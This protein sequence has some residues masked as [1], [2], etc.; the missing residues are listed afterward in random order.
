MTALLIPLY[1][2]EMLLAAA[3]C[4]LFLLGA[5]KSPAARRFAPILSTGV[6]LA[7]VGGLLWFGAD[8]AK[9]VASNQKTTEY[10]APF[11]FYIKLLSAAVGILFVLLAWPTNEHLTGNIALDVGA[12]VGEFFALL[13]LCIAGIFLAAGADDIIMLFL[14]IELASIPTYIMVSISRPLPV[15]QEAGVK[16]FFLGAMAAALMLFGFSYLYGT[17][18]STSLTVIREQFHPGLG[19][20]VNLKFAADGKTVTEIA[21]HSHGEEGQLLLGVDTAKNTVTI[22]GDHAANPTYVLQGA[23][24]SVPAAAITLDGAPAALGALP[25]GSAWQLLA[26]VVLLMGFAFKIAAVP[27]HSYAGDVYT[28]A[29][30]PVTALLA[31]VPK[32]TGM[33]AVIKILAVAAGSNWVSPPIIVKLLFVMAVLTMTFG[34][35]LG[36][37]Q[38]NIKRLLAYSSVAHSGYM[39]VAL[40]ALMAGHGMPAPDGQPT[41]QT[42][43]IS[44]VLFYLCAYG[45]MNAG[46]FGILMLLPG[47]TDT[48]GRHDSEGRPLPTASSAET[49]NDIAGQGRRH[50]ALGLCM[51][52][53]CFSLTGLPLTIGFLGKVLLIQPAFAIWNQPGGNPFGQLMIW[54]VVLTMINAAISAAYYL[55]IIRV[56][57]LQS[58]QGDSPVPVPYTYPKPLFFSRPVTIAIVLSVTGTIFFGTII[59]GTNLLTDRIKIAAQS[60]G[61]VKEAPAVSK[62]PVV[63]APPAHSDS[64]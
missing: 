8:C 60:I 21:A 23:G 61:G 28:G 19:A 6:L 48:H 47:R 36:L 2:P 59:P 16:Y 56:L 43:A 13:L 57:F 15:A 54:L 26:I 9:E 58:E 50:V 7:I 45:I 24:A 32:T 53:C 25:S 63:A 20:K 3:A 30:T 41:F 22:Q 33:V 12:E 34:N 39:L 18:G 27:L 35:V 62:A 52:V 37:L 31:F 14:G 46:A 1:W 17:T 38:Q 51:A 11:A 29:A 42:T 40:T 5:S 44:A 10:F 64:R 49:L 55:K 4:V